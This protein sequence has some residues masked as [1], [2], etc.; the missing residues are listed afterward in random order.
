MNVDE[1]RY[2]QKSISSTFADGRQFSELIESLEGNPGLANS[3]GIQIEVYDDNGVYRSQ[4]NRRLY[5][6]KMA[7]IT[8]IKANLSNDEER[9][10]RKNTSTNGGID[11]K[12]RGRRN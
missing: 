2:T 12:I 7:G 11:I 6:F 9:F 8:E 10:K 1:I 5:C 3:N 4:D